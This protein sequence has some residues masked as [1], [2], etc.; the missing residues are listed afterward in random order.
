MCRGLGGANIHQGDCIIH[1]AT[2]R[3]H[4]RILAL[5]PFIVLSAK[6][7]VWGHADSPTGQSGSANRP[8]PWYQLRS[9]WVLGLDP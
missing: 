3:F 9:P 6:C 4:L 1:G 7:M 5:A 8:S 2:C